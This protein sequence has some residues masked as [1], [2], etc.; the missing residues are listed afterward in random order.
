M[1][2]ECRENFRRRYDD[3]FIVS[4]PFLSLR[5]CHLRASARL[6]V[7]LGYRFQ[8]AQQMAEPISCR[9]PQGRRYRTS[10]KQVASHIQVLRNMW[11]GEKGLYCH[12]D[13]SMTRLKF[14]PLRV[15]TRCRR[16]RAF[17]GKRF[18]CSEIRSFSRSS[19]RCACERRAE[20]RA[21][22][23]RSSHSL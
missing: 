21:I 9:L 18:T 3:S 17:P 16:R 20:G 8:R 15:S 19:V 6:G 2:R 13:S 22:A 14:S 10:K 7:S 1:A 12:Y 23:V 11:K 5:V 4:W